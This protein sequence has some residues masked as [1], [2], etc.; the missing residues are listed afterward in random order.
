MDK[1]ELDLQRALKR[2]EAYWYEDGLAEIALGLW[3][4]VLALAFLVEG[5]GRAPIESFTA[6]FPIV[7]A[8]G[9]YVLG[10]R[11]VLATK[12]RWVYPRTGEVRYRLPS[13]KEHFWWLVLAEAAAV[14]AMLAALWASRHYGVAGPRLALAN[15]LALAALVLVLARDSG[16]QRRFVVLA[17]LSV[18]F[19]TLGTTL[20]P[21]EDLAAA[22]LYG[23]LSLAFVASGAMALRGYAGRAPATPTERNER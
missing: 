19:G 21:N 20:G 12:A 14:G 7:W 2:P 4:V 10:R 16:W 22:I 3:G 11:A 5:I 18:L 1:V 23:A 6:L 8:P 17:A 9:G 13:M 15:G